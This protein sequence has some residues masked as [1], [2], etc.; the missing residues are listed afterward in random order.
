MPP[1]NYNCDYYKHWINK[2]VS[3]VCDLLD[4]MGSVLTM[5]DFMAKFGVKTSFLEYGG[6]IKAIKQSF[7]TAMMGKEGASIC[8]PFIPFNFRLLLQ[9]KKKL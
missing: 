7:G 8:F 1:V 3:Y 4:E 9:D 6:I 5:V 2:G